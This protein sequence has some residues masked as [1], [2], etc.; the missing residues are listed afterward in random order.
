MATKQT[1]QPRT[2]SY[3]VDLFKGGMDSDASPYTIADGQAVLGENVDFYRDNTLRSRRGYELTANV[4]KDGQFITQRMNSEVRRFYREA[5]YYKSEYLANHKLEG[6]ATGTHNFVRILNGILAVEPSGIVLM[7]SDGIQAAAVDTP[8]PLTGS[9]SVGGKLKEGTYTYVYNYLLSGGFESP[10]SE[11]LEVVVKQSDSKVELQF[12]TNPDHP[13]LYKI[14]LYRKNPGDGFPLFIKEL[15]TDTLTY[16]D[17]GDGQS[18]LMP[19]QGI[20]QLPG[21]NLALI[22]NRRLFTVDGATLNYSYPGVYAY[23]NVF[24]SEKVNLP[25]GEPITAICPLGQGVIF[26]G[27]ETALYMNGVPSEGG[28]FN[29]MPVPDGC[30]S[31]TAWTQAE[32]GTLFYVGKSGIYAMQGAAAQRISDPVN[33]RFRNYTAGELRSA[34][35]IFDQQ[36]RRLLVALPNEILVYYF[37]TKAWSV[38][39]LPGAELDWFEGRIHIYYDG[40]FGILGEAENDDGNP[41]KGKFVSGLHGMDDQT[42]HKLFRRMGLQLS[43]INSDKI[44]M[45]IRVTDWDTAFVGLPERAERGSMWDVDLWDVGQWSGN[46]DSVQTV[47]LPDYIQGRYIQFTITFETNNATNFVI[48]G[49]VV[50]EY[51][52]RYRYGRN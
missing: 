31:Q 51:R 12:P 7:D 20:R 29:P 16:V 47:S 13:K 23:S 10:Q 33:D 36:E 41:I 19:L 37:T 18:A 40:K 52:P 39:T 30:V 44:N 5:G 21:G 38:W 50:F 49:P 34:T 45:G 14:R 28:A 22:H 43:A 24:W 46:V 2:L 32:D 8:L 1:V 42:N 35:M 17:T 48:M 26:F 25:T 6:N 4:N 27:L 15:P 3:S 9:S 11:E